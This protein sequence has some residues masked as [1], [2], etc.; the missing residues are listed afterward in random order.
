MTLCNFTAIDFE[1]AQPNRVS[2]CQIGL[3]RV[4]CGRIVKEVS[5][6]VQ[7]PQNFFWR[8]FT[9]IHGIAPAQTRTALTFDQ[10]WPN[11]APFIEHQTV[12]AH[13][14]AFDFQAL[15]LTL[16]YYGLQAPPFEERCTYKIF[17]QNLSALCDKFNIPLE[18]HNA[19]SDAKACAALFEIYLQNKHL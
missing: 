15:K 19:L 11:I 5:C 7:P 18:H 12:V 2:I 3:V 16:D 4:E 17:K 13:N 14:G 8:R 6:L 1:T 9:D 10:T